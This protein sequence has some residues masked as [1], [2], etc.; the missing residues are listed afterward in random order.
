MRHAKTGNRLGRT[1][2]HR[3]A[4]IRDLAKA[5]LL[6]QRI[7]TT[8]PKAKEARKLVDRLITFGKAGTLASRRR[9][10]AILCDHGLVKD[11]FERISP[12]FKSRLGGYTR[13]IPLATRRGDNAQLAFLELTEKE[14]VIV[15]KSKTQ[16]QAKPSESLTVEKTVAKDLATQ[17]KAAPELKKEPPK[18]EAPRPHPK[19][20]IPPHERPKPR[21]SFFTGLRNMF[22]KRPPSRG[23]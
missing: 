18:P 22:R 2:A 12:R 8:K 15:S 9:A 14:E 10:F 16:A 1:S 13:I 11:L 17:P 20:E 7:C 21:P 19:K 23:S 6:E 5:T 3:K 4:T